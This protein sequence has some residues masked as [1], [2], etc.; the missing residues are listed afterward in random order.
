MEKF[1][2]KRWMKINELKE[3]KKSMKWPKLNWKRNKMAEEKTP[4]K[5]KFKTGDVVYSSPAV[6]DGVVYFG[7]DDNHLYAFDA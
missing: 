6:V 4:L 3:V 2:V 5:W 1:I 7:S